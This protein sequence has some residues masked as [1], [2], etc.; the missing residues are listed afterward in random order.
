MTI[1]REI[2]PYDFLM[3]ESWECE[4]LR[5]E[6]YAADIDSDDF[7]AYVEEVIGEECSATSLNDFFRFNED[8]ILEYFGLKVDEDDED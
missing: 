1:T 2:S 3:N 7:D 6:I 8:E 5:N 4:S